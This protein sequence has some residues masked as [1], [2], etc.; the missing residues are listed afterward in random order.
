MDE[1]III[2][3]YG[4]NK[5][6]GGK[7]VFISYL[8]GDWGRGGFGPRFHVDLMIDGKSMIT[9]KDAHWSDHYRKS[10]TVYS[11]KDKESVLQAAIAWANE[12]YGPREFVRNRMGDYV[13]K[14][15][16]EKY[17]LP[18]RERRKKEK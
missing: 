17:P 16:N 4:Q 2:N 12:T 13:E 18:K 7:R 15:V 1:P 8:P 3:T 6:A 5:A 14:E 10:F 11:R 9:D